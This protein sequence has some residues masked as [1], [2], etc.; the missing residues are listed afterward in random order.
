MFMY[1]QLSKFSLSVLVFFF[2]YIGSAANADDAVDYFE[3]LPTSI[4]CTEHAKNEG[5]NNGVRVFYLSMVT[6]NGGGGRTIVIYASPRLDKKIVFQGPKGTRDKS[7][8]I[9]QSNLGDFCSKHQGRTLKEFVDGG[10]TR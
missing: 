9:V 3:T 8:K 5:E 7:V 4:L 6:F 10:L 2:G 1:R